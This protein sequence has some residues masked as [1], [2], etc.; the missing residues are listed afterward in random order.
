[1]GIFFV[2]LAV[3]AALAASV[4]FLGMIA[5]LFWAIVHRLDGGSTL[6]SSWRGTEGAG[7]VC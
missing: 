5:R 2:L 7:Y 4:F 3:L 1:M 6:C